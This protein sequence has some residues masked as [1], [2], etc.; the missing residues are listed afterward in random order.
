MVVFLHKNQVNRLQYKVFGGQDQ[1]G[2]NVHIVIKKK[3]SSAVFRCFVVKFS[4]ST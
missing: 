4:F 2:E 1:F 3:C